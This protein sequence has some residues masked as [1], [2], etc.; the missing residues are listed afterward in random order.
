MTRHH[1]FCTVEGCS[2]VPKGK[3]CAMHK[4]RWHRN[5]SYDDPRKEFKNNP[6]HSEKILKICKKHGNLEHKNIYTNPSTLRMHCKICTNASYKKTSRQKIVKENYFDGRK[7]FVSILCAH[8][9]EDRLLTN[10]TKYW[11]TRKHPIC[12]DCQRLFGRKSL[13]K[14]NFNM[15]L[16]EYEDK[17]KKQN[18]VCAICKNPETVLHH[19]TKKLCSLSVDHNHKTN[20]NRGLL[21]Q[22]C[23]F[24]IGYFKENPVFIRNALLYLEEYES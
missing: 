17:L 5:K 9:K 18:N 1:E 24:G 19:S 8:C 21:C 6:N 22:L 7:D 23:N 14:K 13:L 15:T 3:I 2:N 20:K 11:L 4:S 10:F 12:I 16:D